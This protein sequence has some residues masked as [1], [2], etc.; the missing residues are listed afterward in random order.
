VTWEDVTLAVTLEGPG[1]GHIERAEA[2]ATARVSTGTQPAGATQAFLEALARGAPRA[3]PFA[4]A[5]EI[6]ASWDGASCLAEADNDAAAGTYRLSFANQADAFVGF[7]MVAVESPHT[8]QQVRRVA[9]TLDVAAGEPP[10]DWI[11]IIGQVQADAG[12]SALGVVHIGSALVGPVCAAT[13][14]DSAVPMYHVGEP[15]PTR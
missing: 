5:G 12:R 11:S 9:A 6:R 1:A 2:G 14:G 15:L 13:E 10:P 7:A 8:W 4:L 3:E